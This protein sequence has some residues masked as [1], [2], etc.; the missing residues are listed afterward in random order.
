[1]FQNT[2]LKLFD[3]SRSVHVRCSQCNTWFDNPP[4]KCK[5]NIDGCQITIQFEEEQQRYRNLPHLYC[6]VSGGY[7]SG[8]TYFILSLISNLTKPKQEL[9]TLLESLNIRIDFAHRGIKTRFQMLEGR[10]RKGKLE[11]TIKGAQLSTEPYDLLITKGE[12]QTLL[13]LFNSSGE[14]YERPEIEDEP[15]TPLRHEVAAINAMLYFIDPLQ[16]SGLNRLLGNPSISPRDLDVLQTIYDVLN[17][18]RNVTKISI[19]LAVNISKFDLLHQVNGISIQQ[20]Y[21]NLRDLLYEIDRGD[22]TLNNSVSM[23]IKNLLST[24]VTSKPDDKIGTALEIAPKGIYAPFF[25]I[26][27]QLN[28]I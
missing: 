1:M 24:S 4:A 20:P 7:A 27:R 11:G 5:K 15:K 28:I 12:Q 13:S 26:L 17:K 2:R 3:M 16:D 21:V 6:G 23:Q 22:S 8:K 9:K 25:W 19:P 10:S 14:I 18:N